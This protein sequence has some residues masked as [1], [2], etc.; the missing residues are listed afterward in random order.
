MLPARVEEVDKLIGLELGAD[1][2]VVKPFSPREVVARI[3]T[4][5]KRVNASVAKGEIIRAG[6][7]TI[8][9]G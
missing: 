6:N 9:L 8:D 7:L 5:L 4:I 2:Y 3:K 1:D